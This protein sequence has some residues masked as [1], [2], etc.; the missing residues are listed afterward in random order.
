VNVL[1]GWHTLVVVVPVL[2][3]IAAPF[4]LY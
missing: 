4:T 3:M 1:F 2:A